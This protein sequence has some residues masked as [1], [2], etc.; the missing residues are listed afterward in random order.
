VAKAPGWQSAVSCS[1]VG[2]LAGSASKAATERSS[3]QYWPDQHDC[4]RHEQQE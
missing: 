1:P 4:K 3:S 2:A